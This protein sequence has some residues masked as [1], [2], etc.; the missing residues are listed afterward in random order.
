[1]NRSNGCLLKILLSLFFFNSISLYLYF[2][3]HPG[4]KNQPTWKGRG[5]SLSETRPRPRQPRF[6]AGS[7]AKPWPILP[8]YLPWSQNPDAP[9]RS[10]EGYFGNGFTRRIDVRP[11]RSDPTGI[12]GGGGWFRCWYS[13]TL[14]SSMC[15]GGRLRM[16][17]EKIKMSVG[18]ESLE[19]VI[20]RNE[21]EELPEFE[22]GAFELE[23]GG[24]GFRG[25]KK[26]VR[27]KFL[28][29]FVPRDMVSRHTMR[30]LIDSIQVVGE[31]EFQCYEVRV[32]PPLY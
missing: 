20:G 26:L 31:S 12:G 24:E 25:G 2:S 11:R 32:F 8:S 9:L 16:V 7:R 29:E 5:T 30:G 6:P 27:E 14:R 17:P 1:M 21:A 22:R 18:G 19:A 10:C 23:G 3:P 28:D 15:E 13:E 4:H